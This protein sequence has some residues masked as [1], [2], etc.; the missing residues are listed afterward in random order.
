MRIHHIEILCRDLKF[1]VHKFCNSF[2][3][4]VHGKWK[5][6]LYDFKEK[7]VLKRDTTYFVMHEDTQ[8]SCDYVQNI[9]LEVASVAEIC[10]SIP[11]EFISADVTSI[12]EEGCKHRFMSQSNPHDMRNLS[13]VE[14]AL[15]NS[16][17][18]NVQHTLINKSNYYGPFLPNFTSIDSAIDNHIYRGSLV[19]SKNQIIE[20]K[21]S[22]CKSSSNSLFL[23]HIAFAV[24]TNTS[25]DLME[26]YS[27]YLLMSRCKVNDKEDA[28][29]FKVETLNSSGDILGLKLTAMQYHFC[30][31]QSLK[32]TQNKNN[33]NQNV[34]IVFGESLR[35]QGNELIF[36][37]EENTIIFFQFP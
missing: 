23:D 11:R 35:G 9:A 1:Q 32:I 17:V 28:D 7:I 31:E 29:G 10:K 37:F 24:N 14:A 33:D 27:K 26:W 19:P 2:G 12:V 22:V 34:K 13:K 21:S 36:K 6:G 30:S 16:P 8:S 5:D 25:F 15:L 4:K 3:F 20:F 18:G